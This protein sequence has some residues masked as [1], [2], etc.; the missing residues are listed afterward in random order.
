MVYSVSMDDNPVK[1][2]KAVEADG[3]NWVNVSDLKGTA[4]EIYKIYK[5][6]GL[7][8]TYLIDRSNNTIVAKNI[9]GL[10]LKKFVEDYYKK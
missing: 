10:E 5:I 2:K 8:T 9:R 6:E 1:W 4:S 7:P 3:M